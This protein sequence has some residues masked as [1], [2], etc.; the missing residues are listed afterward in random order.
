[1]LNLLHWRELQGNFSFFGAYFE[2][3]FLVLAQDVTAI[4]LF[5]LVL[6]LGC[7]AYATLAVLR[8]VAEGLGVTAPQSRP[9]YLIAGMAGA[10]L[11]FSY[12]STLRVPSYN[13][14]ALCAAL[15]ATGLLLNL[16]SAPA[17]ARAKAWPMLAYGLA[18]GACGMNKASSGL[19]LA[20]MH[21][22]FLLCAARP[23]VVT[24]G[25]RFVALCLAGIALNLIVLTL[26]AP[27]WFRQLLE[28]VALVSS[29]DGRGLL[30][31]ADLVRWQLQTLVLQYLHWGALGVVLYL[32][33]VWAERRGLVKLAGVP[34]LLLVSA[35]AAA[36]AGAS[37]ASLWW[38]VV[39]GVALLLTVGAAWRHAGPTFV[40][41][42][43]RP[44]ALVLLLLFLPLALSFGTNM[45]VL[46][47]A[48]TNAAF[49]V[50]ALLAALVLAGREGALPRPVLAAALALL[51]L[52][53]LAFQWRAATQAD[54]AYR[55]LQP[56]AAQ[57]VPVSVGA[58]G[59]RLQVDADTANALREVSGALAAAGWTTGTP[60]LDFTGD[61]PGWI[62]AMGGQPV[63]VAW[64]LGGYP[65]SA[66]TAARVLQAQPPE[67]LR[68]SWLL[69]SDTNPRR[70]ANWQTLLTARMGEATHERVA[71]VSVV[72]PYRW[73]KD[74]P[75]RVD[76][77]L[78]RPRPP[79]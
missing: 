18:L 20:A 58:A 56:L 37:D 28:G 57:G 71:T 1:L 17:G 59:A 49:A 16:L 44:V 70:I 32:G 8:Y 46:A 12:L 27:H 68:R 53:G 31:L 64:L 2:L 19:A 54:Q 38:P 75:A 76:L 33:G 78:W 51:C 25:L 77:Q 4:R 13:L 48:K 39:A 79:L 26:A 45:P 42:L 73:G 72:A 62:Y 61:G 9:G 34:E 50:L 23:W 43:G 35:A 65:G 69:V 30:A 60:V 63:G 10:M 7:S 74:A 3:P 55:Q 11:Y 47:H 36:L 41:A 15:L 52:P 21:A 29:T 67:L 6:V 24:N 5:S 14:G 40:G 22:L 66:K